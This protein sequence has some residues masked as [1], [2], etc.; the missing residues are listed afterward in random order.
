MPCTFQPQPELPGVIL[1]TPR[2]FGDDRGWFMETF[3][4]SEFAVNGVPDT[5]RQDNHSRST[6]RGVIRGLH[7]QLDPMAQGKLVR[8]IVGAVY[9]VAVDIRRRSPTY[10]RWLAVELTDD[11][12]RMLWVPAGF[13]H[14]FCTLTDVSEV[15]YKT[16][17]EYSPQHE[18]SIRWDDPDL[19][20]AWPTNTPILSAK[21][22]MA[23]SLPN[24]DNTFTW[25]SRS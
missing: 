12:R 8:C 7:Y 15:V 21:D 5:F 20:I 11:N 17:N 24:A 6:V 13:A 22:A 18:R 16:T 3:K 10:A 9:D 25:S 1:I 19:G 14:G 23:P 2:A 4:Q